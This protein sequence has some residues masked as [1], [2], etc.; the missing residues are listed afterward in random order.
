M[1]DLILTPIPSSSTPEGIDVGIGVVGVFTL[2]I[3]FLG[4]TGFG[5]E[6][7]G[8]IETRAG[9]DPELPTPALKFVTV[10]GLAAILAQENKTECL[11]FSCPLSS[12]SFSRP[13]SFSLPPPSPE[14]PS[15][16]LTFL[17]GDLGGGLMMG[18]V[19]GGA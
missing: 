4:D 5:G 13:W 7:P 6:G 14:P 1:E 9:F 16:L 11:S 3:G 19:G 12:F 8:P 2:A 17:R 15:P 18:G 10:L